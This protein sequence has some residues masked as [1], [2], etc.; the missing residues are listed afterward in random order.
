MKT[1]II[2]A[3]VTIVACSD[4]NT[5]TDSGPQNGQDAGKDVAQQND[6]GPSNDAGPDAPD[7]CATG[8]KFDNTLVPGYPNNIPQP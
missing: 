1:R 7:P 3:L 5:Q 2:L 6:S 4:N 8:L